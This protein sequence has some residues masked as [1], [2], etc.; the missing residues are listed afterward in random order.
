MKILRNKAY[1][2]AGFLGNPSDGYH[3]KTISFIVQNFSAEVVL[4][5]WDSVEIVLAEQD[6]ARF[7]SVRDLA[8]DVKLHGYYGGIRLVKATIKRFVEYCRERD[9]EL[10]DQNFSIR[11]SSDIPRQ[12]G[13][14][15]SSSIIVATLRCLMEF[16]DVKIP[17]QAQP[18]FVLTVEQ[19][20]LGI[21]A[22]LQDRVI[23]VYEGLVYMDFNQ[24]AE[25]LSDGFKTYKYEHLNP[26]QLPNIYVAYHDGLSEPTEVYHNDI[27]GRVLRGEQIVVDAMNRFAEIAEEGREALVTIDFDLLS[28]LINENFDLRQSIS[29]LPNWQVEMIQ[30]A[31]AC[32]VSAKFAGSGGAIVGTYQN[33]KMLE[34]LRDRMASIGVKT[35]L[36]K[37]KSS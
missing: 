16:Y 19:E 37:I 15:G 18:T 22:G 4:Y 11:Y 13:L 14:A 24:S 5:E 9:I 34:K 27:R 28:D 36:P 23:Q 31:R 33:E 12:V 2:R 10:H 35:I 25:N 6:R 29:K 20:E 1:A 8:N 21:S 7:R 3:G 17:L 32:G 26:D 30:V